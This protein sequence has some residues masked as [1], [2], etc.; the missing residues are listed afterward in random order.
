MAPRRL[1]LPLLVVFALQPLLSAQTPYKPSSEQL[2][3]AYRRADQWG[4]RARD[5]TF[6]LSLNATWINN[7]LFWYRKE[8]KGNSQEFILVEAAK[9]A[10]KP[11]F[12]HKRL[13]EALSKTLGRAVEPT[14]LPFQTIRLASDLGQVEFDIQSKHYRCNLGTYVV[15]E[16]EAESRQNPNRGQGNRNSSPDGKWTA[17]IVD[18]KVEVEPRDG[19]PF[20]LGADGSFTQVRWAPDSKRLVGFRLIPGDRKQVSILQSS[21]TNTTR[22]QVRTRNYDQPGDK[23]DTFEL[24]VFDP[25][26]K[27]ERKVGIDPIVGGGQPWAGAPGIDWRNNGSSFIVDYSI[28]GYQAYR[29]DKVDVGTGKV[30]TLVDERSP[31]FVDTTSIIMRLL[32]KTDEFIWRSERDGWGHLYLIDGRTGTAKNQITSGPWVVRSIEWIDEDKRELCF[33][34]NARDFGNVGA[35]VPLSAKD[36]YLIRCYRVGFDGKGLTELTPGPGTHTIQWSPDR[37]FYVDTYSRIDMAPVHE[38]RRAS[39]GKLVC[40]LE[41]T[42]ISELLSRGVKLPEVFMAKARDG[43][44]DIW[45]IIVRPSNFDPSRSYPVIENIYAGPHDSHVPKRFFPILRM[46]S[47]AELGFIVVQ[48]DGM[49][50]RN[51]GKKFHDVCWKNIADAGFPDRILWMQAMAKKYPQADIGR[52]GIYGTSAGG[53]NS[54]GALLFHP[55][56]YKVA[57]S[58]CGCHDNRI[59]KMWWN[60]QWM[61][62]PVGPHY[63]EQSNITNAGKLQGRLLLLVGELDTNVPPEST[64]R[65]CD[66][67]IKERKEFEFV[68]LPGMDHTDGGFYGERKRRDFFVKHLLGVEP[69]NWNSL[70]LSREPLV[71]ETWDR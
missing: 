52:V 27:S 53:Q 54:T 44:T 8:L 61:G 4:G 32:S 14:K 46:Q 47:L 57:V 34:A 20:T 12:D 49:G 1:F 71:Q 40:E 28:R 56:F 38:L 5:A 42:D 29:V 23:L 37:K 31:T 6:N 24:Y 21:A 18:G 45:G 26:S 9:A 60:E 51:R 33:T 69:P 58:S 63:D 19:T 2:L 43:Q 67:L 30:T 48:I 70:P 68:I 36:P 22:G 64:I 59:D 62:Y 15:S 11:A 66:A 50:T 17:R 3:E 13:A 25:A 39:D 7:E 55:D 16:Y 35:S 41:K 65:L 10:K